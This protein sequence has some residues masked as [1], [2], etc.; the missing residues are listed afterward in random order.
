MTTLE[1]MAG[2]LASLRLSFLP[3][4]FPGLRFRERRAARSPGEFGLTFT[5][6]QYSPRDGLLF[7][8]I[9]SFS[10]RFPNTPPLLSPRSKRHNFSEH[11]PNETVPSCRPSTTTAT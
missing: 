9:H 10:V 5:S 1:R 7:L 8:L 3:L 6:P 11:S 4:R 2:K